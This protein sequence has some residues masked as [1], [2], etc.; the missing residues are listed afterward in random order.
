MVAVGFLR[1]DFGLY[2]GGLKKPG[3]GRI[4]VVRLVAI[5]R[6]DPGPGISFDDAG[7]VALVF[8]GLAGESDF[9]G[10]ELDGF[11]VPFQT[12]GGQFTFWHFT[13]P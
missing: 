3:I 6:R 2:Q 1:P 10:M 11:A 9:R 13:F 7:Y 5:Q 4:A 8:E 12:D